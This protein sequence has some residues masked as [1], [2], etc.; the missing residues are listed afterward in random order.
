MTDD[1]WLAYLYERHSRSVIAEWA[2]SLRFFR[3]CR[4]HGGHAN[5]G[6]RLLIALG[7][8]DRADL[9]RKFEGLGI[10]LKVLPEDEPTP[11][12]GRSYRGDEY[13]KFR[14]RIKQYPEIQQPGHV[15][16]SGVAAHAWVERDRLAISIANEADPYEVTEAAVSGAGRVELLIAQLAEAVIDPPEDT[17]HCICPKYYPELWANA[18]IANVRRK[19][20][21]SSDLALHN[22]PAPATPTKAPREIVESWVRMLAKG[23]WTAADVAGVIEMQIS[24]SDDPKLF[25]LVPVEVLAAMREDVALFQQHGRWIIAAGGDGV[26]HTNM[27][28][29]FSEMMN[30]AGLIG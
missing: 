7:V 21:Y 25:D 19:E 17:R 3:Y 23:L 30:A 29:K 13:A 6:D 20:L 1:R 18:S 10:P 12:P 9:E 8:G 4:A 11:V 22:A 24:L 27:M 15:R 14:P 26:D 16:L 5:D 28:R 2:L